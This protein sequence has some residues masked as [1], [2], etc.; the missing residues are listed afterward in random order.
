MSR[1]SFMAAR[2]LTMDSAP[3]MPRDST[4]LEVTASIT[5]VVIMVMAT[6]E[7]PKLEEYMTPAKVFLYTRKMNMPIPKARASANAI[8]SKL[9]LETF[10]RKLD[11]KIS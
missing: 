1:G 5:R 10:S 2:N 9:T 6:R 4:T 11:L 8:S 7:T 3:T